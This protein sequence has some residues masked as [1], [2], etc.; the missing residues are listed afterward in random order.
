MKSN[1]LFGYLLGALAQ[2]PT[3]SR[4]LRRIIG[5]SFLYVFEGEAPGF[6]SS[7]TGKP[8]LFNERWWD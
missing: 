4:A 8:N 7:A 3:P 6:C 2:L 5:Y 1:S